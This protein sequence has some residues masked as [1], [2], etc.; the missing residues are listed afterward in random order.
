[1]IGCAEILRMRVRQKM[2]PA[3]VHLVVAPDYGRPLIEHPCEVFIRLDEPIELLDLR[4][5]YKLTVCA[6][7]HET[8]TNRVIEYL[9][10]IIA[11]EPRELVA[12]WVEDETGEPVTRWW[13]ANGWSDEG[14]AA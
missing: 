14:W 13:T 6:Y 3:V 11:N 2:A 4:P 10:A 7:F 12:T 8:S 9:E 5:L 1:M